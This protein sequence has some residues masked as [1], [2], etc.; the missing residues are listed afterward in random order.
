MPALEKLLEGKSI[1]DKI[2]PTLSPSEGYGIPSEDLVRHVPK[3]EFS[4]VSEL[5][6]GM[7]FQ[8]DSKNGPV[9]F[10]VMEITDD[11]VV[12]DGKHTHLQAK[13]STSKLR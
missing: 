7:H 5:A 3:S 2:S 12:L 4:E 8:V 1:G 6:V 11:K 13:S 9:V 10:E